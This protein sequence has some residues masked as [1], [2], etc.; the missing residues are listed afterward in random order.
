MMRRSRNRAFTLIEVI[1][2]LGIFSL[3]ATA[4]FFSVQ[5][6][7]TASAVL[8]QEQMRSRKVDAF[9]NWCRRGFRNLG[10]R[11]EIILRT[12]ETGNAGLAVELVIRRA[13]GAFSLGEFDALGADVILAAIPDGRGGAALS[14]AR[15]PGSWSLQES[16]ERLQ[17]G[18]WLPMLDGIRLLRWGFWN[19]LEETFQEEWPEGRPLPELLRLQLTLDTGE[20]VEAVFRPPKLENRGDPSGLGTRRTMRRRMKM[21]SRRREVRPGRTN[22]SKSRHRRVNSPGGIFRRR[23]FVAL[24]QGAFRGVTRMADFF[25]IYAD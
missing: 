21:G 11:S 22:P 6:V 19:P 3:L 20:E 10:P 4:L 25:P 15:F 7:T 8:G 18:D 16:A 2:A 12:R 13:P 24:R 23:F 17:P 5:A 1:L 9:L 14:I